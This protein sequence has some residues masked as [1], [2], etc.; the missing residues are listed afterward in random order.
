MWSLTNQTF[1]Y[2][3]QCSFETVSKFDIITRKKI[4][5]QKSCYQKLGIGGGFWSP[6]KI[7]PKKLSETTIIVIKTSVKATEKK[8]K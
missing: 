8:G 1:H 4:K 6:E 7:S 5:Y 2:L 3:S